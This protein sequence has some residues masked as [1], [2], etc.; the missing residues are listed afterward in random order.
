MIN[1]P[2]RFF[3]FSGSDTDYLDIEEISESEFVDLY[4]ANPDCRLDY[5]RHT[6]FSNGVNQIC[7]TLNA[8]RE[9]N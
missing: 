4:A 8:R 1:C 6:V 5:E 2:I 9:S 7:L 3:A